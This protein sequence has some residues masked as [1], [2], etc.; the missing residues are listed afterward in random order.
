MSKKHKR[1]TSAQTGTAKKP[2]D[3]P[4]SSIREKVNF[5]FD[6]IDTGSEWDLAAISSEDLAELLGFLKSISHSTIGELFGPNGPGKH[7]PN[8]DSG[9]NPSAVRRL[10][11]VYE[12]QDSIHRLRLSGK[13]RLFG[14]LEGHKFS[15]VWWDP[16][17]L[18]W[19]SSKR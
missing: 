8:I 10:V 2:F 13:K 3:S 7:Y 6:R 5:R 14:F 12:G 9:M 11:D 15:I 17:H 18:V 19:P 1:P 4:V 16:E